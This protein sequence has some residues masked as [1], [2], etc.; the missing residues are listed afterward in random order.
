MSTK[1]RESS[2]VLTHT[3]T[4]THTHTQECLKIS[5]ENLDAVGMP[6]NSILKAVKVSLYH[7]I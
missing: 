2:K 5:S 4:H 1:M 7:V 3:H 6:K